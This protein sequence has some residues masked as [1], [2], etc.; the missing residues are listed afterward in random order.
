MAETNDYNLPIRQNI[1]AGTFLAA[2]SPMFL[3]LAPFLIKNGPKWLGQQLGLDAPEKMTLAFHEWYKSENNGQFF[4]NNTPL[5]LAQLPQFF[6]LLRQKTWGKSGPNYWPPT[7]E[8]SSWIAR[9]MG[10]NPAEPA[11]RATIVKLKSFLLMVGY[12]TPEAIAFGEWLSGKRTGYEKLLLGAKIGA[13]VGVGIILYR[14]R[15][16][17][18]SIIGKVQGK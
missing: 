8:M 4:T 3:V 16:G 12:N 17:L 1:G 5:V 18:K 13:V 2:F 7:S 15:T 6:S 14:N 11:I 9:Q 10:D